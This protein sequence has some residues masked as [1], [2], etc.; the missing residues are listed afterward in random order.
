MS[1]RDRFVE[2]KARLN[3][4]AMAGETSVAAA[5]ALR[6]G[7]PAI[8]GHLP[9]G[10]LVAGCH[11]LCPEGPDL[12]DEATSA[13]LAACL[14]GSA[15][16][17]V[18]WTLPR[19]TLFP[20][21]L[22]EAGL[23]PSRVLFVEARTGARGETDVLATAE[24]ALRHGGL[25]GV[26]CEASR[27]SLTASR[28]L[29]LAAEAGRTPC[30]VL[31]PWRRGQAPGVGTACATRWSVGARAS[32]DASG[33]PRAAWQLSLTRCRGGAPASWNVALETGDDPGT[34]LRLRLAAELPG[35][36]TD[37]PDETRASGG[38][39]GRRVA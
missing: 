39:L 10:G 38:R 26:V 33:L 21:A 18:V 32:R 29:Q 27:L 8:D 34:P 15:R 17:Q 24:E 12:P 28:R 22:A 25:A 31:R 2:V 13:Q 7:L 37:A 30:L 4:G 1:R 6:F 20:P 36:A 9:W 11:E 23:C 5:P 35:H 19:L 3:V 16:G 14:L